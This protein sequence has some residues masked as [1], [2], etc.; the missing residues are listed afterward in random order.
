MD[1][2]ATAPGLLQQHTEQKYGLVRG[3]ELDRRLALVLYVQNRAR[4][5]ALTRVLQ[6]P[7][8]VRTAAPGSLLKTASAATT[9]SGPCRTMIPQH[10]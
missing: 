4:E 6:R 8:R 7:A 9:V 5:P 3:E 2:T 10:D 1:A